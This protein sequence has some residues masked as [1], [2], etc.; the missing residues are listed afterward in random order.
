[1]PDIK[2]TDGINAAIDITPNNKSALVKYFKNLSD[3]SIAGALPVLRR[4]VT[5]VDPAIKTITAGVNLSRPIEVGTSQV[6]LKISAG[7]CGSLGIFKPEGV[8]TSLFDPDP[9]GDPIPVAQDDRYVSFSL[10][11]TVTAAG[12]AGPGDL[13]FGFSAASTTMIA[14]Y[15][16]F[17]TKPS[18]PELVDA[19]KSTVAGFTLPMDIAD[20]QEMAIDSIVTLDGTGTLKFS[21]TA[22]LLAVL[23]PLAAASLPAPLPAVSVKQGGSIDIDAD[24]QLSGSYQIRL[25]KLGPQQVRLAYYRKMDEAL[26]IQVSARAGLSADIGGSDVLGKL[27]SAISSDAK[28]D[29]NE[30]KKAGLDKDTV[31]SIEGAIKASIERTLEIAITAELGKSSGHKA[32]FVYD[33]DLVALTPTS[34]AAVHSALDGDLSALTRNS[35]PPLP[36][37]RMVRELLTDVRQSKHALNINLLGIVN[38][39]WVSKLMLEG[40]TLYEPTTGQLVISDAATASRVGS[41]VFNI[42]VADAEKLRQVMAENFLITVAFRGARSTGL[43]SSLVTSHSFFALNQHTSPETVRDELD[44]SVALGLMSTPEQA[45]AVRSAPE[46]GRTL[47]YAKV[48]YDNALSEHLFLDGNGPRPVAFYETAGLDAIAGLVHPGDVDEARLLPASDPNLWQE[49]K[50]AGQARIKALFPTVP[51]PIIGAIIADYSLIRWW[52]DAMNGTAKKL[53]EMQAF[54][55]SHPSVDWEDN[56][57]KKLRSELADH[58]QSVAADTKENFGRPWG[59]L[60][61]FIASG[62]RAA[63][64][65]V[66]IG[67]N[68]SIASSSVT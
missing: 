38:Y 31:Q 63:R 17:A 50:S 15:C 20:L 45:R 29:S 53:A 22:N 16:R 52:S 13:K 55:S 61:M 51:D 65:T 30:L 49:M 23:N 6:D 56:D 26:G 11:G 46:F 19:V 33:I 36:G 66:L 4:G 64:R 8:S 3:F 37:I 47:F 9:Y 1:M 58:L 54:L 42:G 21:G 40:K 62:R 35:D 57:F 25:I 7:L 67:N 12:A 5:L 59:L 28:V 48:D 34:R 18:A 32:A 24:I 2:L 44:V 43:S 68:L 39:G 10:T 14:N 27:I 41:T 60:A